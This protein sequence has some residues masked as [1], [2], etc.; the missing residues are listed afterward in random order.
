V[1][2]ILTVADPGRFPK[3]RDVGA[4]FGLVPRQDD[5]GDRTSQLPITKAGDEHMRRLLVGCAQYIMGPFAPDC[6]LRRYGERLAQRGGKNAKKRAVVAVARKLAVLLHHL[7][8]TGAAYDPFYNVNDKDLSGHRP[9]RTQKSNLTDAL[10]KAAFSV[11]ARLS[12][13]RRKP[14]SRPRWQHRPSRGTS[15]CTEPQRLTKSANGS[16]AKG[17]GGDGMAMKIRAHGSPRRP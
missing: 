3:S 11:T 12:L 2:F 6:D 8:A 15:A 4:C 10:R 7:W 16:E 9:S 17:Y 14:R 1:T 5:S 13:D